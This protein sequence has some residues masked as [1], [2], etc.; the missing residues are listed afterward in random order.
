MTGA[1]PVLGRWGLAPQVRLLRKS[2]S[3]SSLEDAKRLNCRELA[4]ALVQGHSNS[5]VFALLYYV[6]FTRRQC[7]GLL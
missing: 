5:S 2:V 7:K 1:Y 3:V 4:Y 6:A